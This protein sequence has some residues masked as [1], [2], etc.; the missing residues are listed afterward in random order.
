MKKIEDLSVKIECYIDLDKYTIGGY[1][2]DD[3]DITYSKWAK[4]KNFYEKAIKSFNSVYKTA[5]SEM[6]KDIVDFYTNDGVKI[7]S[8]ESSNDLNLYTDDNYVTLYVYFVIDAD[9]DL[10]GVCAEFEYDKNGKC[11]YNWSYH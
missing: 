10:S 5:I 8:I 9:E 2:I 6:T 3:N 1:K 11:D 7:R 4:N